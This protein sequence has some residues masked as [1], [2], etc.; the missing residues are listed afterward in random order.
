MACLEAKPIVVEP[1]EPIQIALEQTEFFLDHGIL[2]DD[3][4]EAAG[5]AGW[6]I[7][8]RDERMRL[9]LEDAGQ[10]RNGALRRNRE[11]HLEMRDGD[12]RNGDA[13]RE[14]LLCPSM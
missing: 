6:I 1:G 8:V 2:R 7:G 11:I 5:F 9:K 13:I 4:G 10:K 14:L 12:S 3:Q